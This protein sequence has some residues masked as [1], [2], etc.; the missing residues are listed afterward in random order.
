MKWL[1]RLWSGRKPSP[2]ATKPPP[3]STTSR[4]PAT[5]PVPDGPAVLPWLL[6]CAALTDTPISEPEKAALA[7]LDKMLALPTMADNLLP[8]AAS[9]IPQLIALLRQTDLPT[10]EIAARV[11]KDAVLTAEVMRLASSSFHSGQ[12][13][14]V[15]LQQAVTRIGLR[16]LQTVMARVLLKPIYQGSQGP[17]SARAAPRLWEHSDG[18][19]RHASML[20]GQAGQPAF[21]GYL[22]GMLHDTGWIVALNLIDR[23]GLAIAVPPSQA[24]ASALEDRVHRLFGHAARRWDITASFTAFAQDA[25]E[26]GPTGGRHPLSAL[27]PQ[28]HRDCM[29]EL[30]GA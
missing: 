25:R 19:A 7:E 3:D 20:A 18:L 28:A 10:A 13:A 14:V 5:A 22:A 27:M 4:A 16:G 15:D 21:D 17:W 8:R 30:A 9:L 12:G 29:R 11:G 6:G 24:F 2:A 1:S 26:H 23:S